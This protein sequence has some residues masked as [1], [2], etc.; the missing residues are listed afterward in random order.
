M[1]SRPRSRSAS[2]I[3][4]AERW[5][6]RNY[7]P[8]PV[9]LARG[10]GVFV[11]DVEGRRY[12]DC[13]SAYSALNQGHN[14]PRIVSA[15]RRQLGRLSLTSRAFHNELMGPLLERLC[16]LT[17][18]DRAILMN[19]GAEA[20]ETAVKAM[21]LWGYKRKG[22]TPGRARIVTASGN[23]HGRTT[24]IVSFSSDPL[25]YEGFGPKT[26]G[27]DQVPYGDARALEAALG[28]NACGVLLEPIQGEAGVILPPQG[29]LRRVRELCSRKRVLFCLDEIQTGLGRTGK[30]FCGEHEGVRPDMV[31]LGKALSG[32]LYPVSAVAAGEEVLGLFTP[33]THGSTYGGNPLACAIALAALDV[34]ERERL[35]QKAAERGR[36]F[37]NLLRTLEHPALAEVRG[38][39]LLL[40]IEFKAPAAKAF[41]KKLAAAGLL[42]KDT[43]E[44]TVRFAPPLIIT[45]SQ[46]AAAFSIIRDALAT[47]AA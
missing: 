7:S 12:F 5:G 3:A 27:F 10:R 37:L 8:L 35:P 43:H 41:C 6:A 4:Q 30:L 17:R 9:V 44:T 19:S 21:R 29:Y 20:V 28:K 1:S 36:Q 24:T 18:M 38:R 14:H 15:A 45:E 34:L 11:W 39:G 13:L 26:P 46:V 31:I 33:G 47:F 23:F 25:A 32:G 16:R 22:I 42:A 2:V 40:A